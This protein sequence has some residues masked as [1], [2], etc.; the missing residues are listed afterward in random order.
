LEKINKLPKIVLKHSRIEI[1][2]Y[3]PGDSSMLE[4]LF[5]LFDQIR[6]E[7]IPLCIEYNDK[8]QQLI[9]PRGMNINLL[10]RIFKEEPYVDKKHD[11][12]IYTNPLPI[13]Y[14]ARDERQVQIIK[15]LVGLD[16]YASMKTKSQLLI[17]STT[18]SGKTFVTV[19]SMCIEGSRMI[20]ITGQIDWLTQW[21]EKILEYTPLS[22][23]NIYTI[24][25]RTS[26]D[27]LFTRDPLQYQVF[28]A[29]HSTL[30]SYA[31]SSKNGW[32]A[33]TEL[34]RYIKCGTKV[35]DE[36]HLFF[37]NMA[38]LDFH[39]NTR[40][41]IYLSAT[42]ERSSRE[43]N[44][45]FQE[46]FKYIPSIELFDP[47]KDP[48]VNY[49][50]VLFNSNPGPSDVRAFSVGQYGFDRNIYMNY[51]CH[52]PNFLKLVTYLIDGALHVPGKVL[53]YVG[54]ND[55]IEYIREYVI[56]QFP[57]LTDSIGIFS[58][59]VRDKDLKSDMLKK[60]FIF[61]T[62]K[63]A[64]AAKDIP[65]LGVCIIL[66][67]PF[68]SKVIARQ[69]LGRCRADN[70]LYI[71]CID[72][73]CQRTKMYYYQKR[74]VFDMYAKSCREIYLSDDSLEQ[75]Y[76]EIIQRYSI[77]KLMTLPVFKR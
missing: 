37:T 67:E 75:K 73:T 2:N 39:T 65:D 18:G 52:R 61:S 63:S 55:C 26:I 24:T 27:K 22:P 8:N 35:F 72:M 53:I 5:S 32:D 76:Q 9:L 71:D 48:H 69:T 29:S 25:G 34:F 58:S 43:E 7:R 62:T 66:N 31:E 51:L 3:K 40:K 70:T 60:K 13:K 46:Y 14:I 74:P 68:K 36:C 50:S 57:F 10:K 6:H 4:Y 42:P 21:Q 20:V 33:I 30:Q 45:I 12:A 54:I 16:E 77:R 47:E 28:L 19:A 41:T 17:N 1:N 59:V 23:E 11:E 44:I 56:Q 49:V 38:A 64:G 15:F